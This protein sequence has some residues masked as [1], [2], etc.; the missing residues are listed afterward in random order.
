M[1]TILQLSDT[2]IVRE[3]HLVSGR[4]DTAGSMAR[5]VARIE[6]MH[7]RIAPVDAVVVSGDVSDDGSPES[8]ECFLSVMAPLD[9]PLY[10][11]PGN[12]DRREPMR[13]AFGKG[14]YLPPSGRLNWRRRVGSV[15]LIG[16]DTL[17]EGQGGGEMDPQTLD[18]LSSALAEAVDRPV[19]LALHH[20][21]FACGIEFMDAIGLRGADAL[22]EVLSRH[23]N[24]IRVVCGHIHSTM[25]ASVGGKVVL[26]APSP[27]SSFAFDARPG[28]VAGF[29]DFEDGILL[30]RWSDGFVSVRIGCQNG[31]GPY[32]F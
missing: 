4:L 23:D 5:I 11:I 24:D 18:F 25:A 17:I 7:D 21:P 14:G 10:V 20:P 13:R 15:D 28:A 2:H 22:A 1:T 6:E 30:H 32:P 8:Y 16:L 3:G 29:F 12:H 26:S 19:L 9:V 31:R 27:C